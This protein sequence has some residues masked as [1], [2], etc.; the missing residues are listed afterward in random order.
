MTVDEESLGPVLLVLFTAFL[1]LDLEETGS[2]KME[3][4]VIGI[5]HYF[6]K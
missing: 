5:S 4:I 2:L 3:E 6:L 1:S